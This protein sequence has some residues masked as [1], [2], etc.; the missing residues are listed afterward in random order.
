[1]ARDKSIQYIQYLVVKPL[2]IITAWRW[3]SYE[4][5]RP[6]QTCGDIFLHSSMQ[7]YFN[8]ARFLGFLWWICFFYVP[9]RFSIGLRAGD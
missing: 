6:S 7:I 8:S 9:Q 1:M 5:I 2:L 4:E 3:F